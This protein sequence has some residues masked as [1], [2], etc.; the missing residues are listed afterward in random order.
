MKK[1]SQ[2]IV[3]DVTQRYINNLLALWELSTKHSSWYSDANQTMQEIASDYNVSVE[4]VAYIIATL[5]PAL[6]WMKNIEGARAFFDEWFGRSDSSNCQT[7]Y[8]TNVKKCSEYMFGV[9]SDAPTGRKVSSFYRNLLGDFDAVTLDRHAIRAARWGMRNLK[10]ESGE[11]KICG[12]EF[13]VIQNAY[14]YAASCAG[15][16]VAEFQATLWTLFAQ[17]SN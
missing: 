15:V 10:S 5:S 2:A 6:S 4:N 12:Q 1:L 16:S 13:S 8:G 7:A 3:N 9:R 11:Q 14:K 17:Q